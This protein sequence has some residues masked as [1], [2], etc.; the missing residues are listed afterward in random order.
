MLEDFEVAIISSAHSTMESKLVQTNLL[1]WFE[2]EPEACQEIICARP[3]DSENPT[4]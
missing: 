3:L 4:C 1:E 2:P